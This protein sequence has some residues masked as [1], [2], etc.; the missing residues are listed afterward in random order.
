MDGTEALALAAATIVAGA[1]SGFLAGLFG[2]GGGTGVVPALYQAL[3]ALGV[4][5]GVRMHLSV[6]TSVGMIVPTSIR[7]FLAHRKRGAVDMELLRS[8]LIPV[9]AGAAIGVIVAAFISDEALR[10]LFGVLA[11]LFGLRLIFAKHT[12]QI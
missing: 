12:W 9:P 10:L 6:A 11:A 2:I 8:W 1:V 4:D 7:S 5:E 3:T